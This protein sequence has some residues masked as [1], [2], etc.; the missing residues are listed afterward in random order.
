MSAQQDWI[1]EG[2]FGERLAVVRQ[3]HGW[4]V[5]EAGLACGIP[6]A[7]WASWEAGKSPQ[8]YVEQCRKIAERAGVDSLWLM[9]GATHTPTDG[10][11]DAPPSPFLSGELIAA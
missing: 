1:P 6:R 3:H 2:T 9:T 10:E 4:N 7:T 11:Y 5:K 8:N